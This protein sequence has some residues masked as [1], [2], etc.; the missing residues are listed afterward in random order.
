MTAQDS[1]ISVLVAEDHLT[2][3]EG[4]R[5]LLEL[6]GDIR[7]QAEVEGGNEAV[8]KALEIRPHVVLMDISLVG[9]DGIEATR[10]LHAQAPEL[11]VLILSAN[12]ELHVVR[13][14]L[15]A[16]ATGYLLKR[17]SGKELRDAVRAAA[18]GIPFFSAE[19]M[20]AVRERA[21]LPPSRAENPSLLTGR[22]TEI[23]Q[24]IAGGYSNREIGEA[25]TISIKTVDTHR[26][27]IM[28][29]LDIHDV[30]GLTRY[31]IRKGLIE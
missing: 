1:K 8:T 31:A 19:V 25:L 24:L 28:S 29:K 14:C 15:N 20:G 3:R 5:M 4:L 7:V 9:L 17:A 16:G 23:L 21:R 30:A 13:A 18:Q 27:H 12:P 11:P 6:E 10:R 26:M 2:L 22:E